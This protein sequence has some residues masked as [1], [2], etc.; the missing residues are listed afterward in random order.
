MATVVEKAGRFG[1]LGEFKSP[2]ALIHAAE[3]FRDAGFKKM[4]GYSPFPIEPLTEALGVA[5]TR[6][7]RLV[8]AGGITGLLTGLSLQVYTTVID[9][10]INIG[11]RPLFSLPSFVPPMYELTILFAAFSAAFGMLLLNGF[12]QPY[13]PV[14]NV[15]RFRETASVD[16]FFLIVEAT[17]PAFNEARIRQLFT[18][19]HAEGVYDV[20]P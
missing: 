12:P 5:P 17:D 3:K 13:H 15:Q 11:A 1:I 8:L 10:P 9:Y 18:E 4:D 7:P 16:G 2:E 6:L 19:V 14:F 20:E